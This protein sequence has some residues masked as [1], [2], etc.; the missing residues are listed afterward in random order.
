MNFDFTAAEQAFAEE[1]RLF[2]RANPPD[3]FPIDGMDAGYGSGAASRAF[4]RALGAQGWLS[5]TWPRRFGGQELPMIRKLV[6]LEELALAGAP[7]GPLSGAEQTA[8]AIIRH[9][10]AHLRSEM[11]PRI[12]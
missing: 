12:A 4:L 3:T 5:M 11:L 10:T 7:F 2:I 6:L 1:V 8:E 9:G